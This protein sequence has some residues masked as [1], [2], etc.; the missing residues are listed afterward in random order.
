MTKK[1]LSNED[2]LRLEISSL[3][4]KL[5]I[6][7]TKIKRKETEYTALFENTNDAYFLI[8]LKTE[9]YIDVNQQALE[10]FGYTKEE[11][12]KLN[13]FDILAPAEKI[14]D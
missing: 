8:D 3:E 5:K 1:E 6:L 13:I 14:K 10:M 11:M 9:L 12:F 4:R 2:E 7:E